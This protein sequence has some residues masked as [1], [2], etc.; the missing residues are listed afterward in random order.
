MTK[1]RIEGDTK[2]E[3]YSLFV[4]VEEGVKDLDDFV[5]KCEHIY[6]DLL[7][8]RNEDGSRYIKT[9]KEAYEHLCEEM[10]Y[11]ILDGCVWGYGK[12][13][14]PI[15]QTRGARVMEESE[16]VRNLHETCTKLMQ[17]FLFFN[18]F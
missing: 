1:F 2:D 8:M 15:R 14:H 9:M 11:R 13:E 17:F 16:A 3:P 10:K 7:I 5:K 12:K 4:K 18:I 6:N